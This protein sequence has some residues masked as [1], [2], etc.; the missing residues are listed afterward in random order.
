MEMSMWSYPA[1]MLIIDMAQEISLGEQA[2][3]PISKEQI[4]KT[5]V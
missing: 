3:D 1:I 2:L 4:A 5:E